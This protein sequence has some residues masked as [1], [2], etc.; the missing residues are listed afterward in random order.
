[1]AAA[2]TTR[3]RSRRAGAGVAPRRS[4]LDGPSV[5]TLGAGVRWDR[6]GRVAMLCVLVA[7]IYLYISA[8]VHMFST[9]RQ[10]A[11]DSAAVAAMEREHAQLVRQ[12]EV[13]SRQETLEVQ[14]RRLG[15]IRP[16]EQPYLVTGL[17]QN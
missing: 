14:A 5:L 10:S 8:G 2:S 16:G 4:A 12:H 7:L 1:M 9:W 17:P 6:V 13:L 15:L 11:H 3:A